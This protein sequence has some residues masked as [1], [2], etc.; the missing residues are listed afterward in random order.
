LRL[1]KD[2]QI[3]GV[4][5]TMYDQRKV[6]NRDVV[7]TIRKYFGE[8]LF[9]TLIRDNVALAEAPAQRKDIFAYSPAS[10]GSEDYLALCKELLTRTEGA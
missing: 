1:N 9:E 2:L 6:L 7:D 4:V 8:L 3:A 10:P 5:A